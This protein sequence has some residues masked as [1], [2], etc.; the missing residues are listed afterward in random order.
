MACYS[1]TFHK[2]CVCFI[3]S[4]A[5]I[6]V[7]FLMR[8]WSKSLLHTSRELNFFPFRDHSEHS[9]NPGQRSVEGYPRVDIWL[10]LHRRGHQ[11]SWPIQG[12]FNQLLSLNGP[13]TKSTCLN[14]TSNFMEGGFHMQFLFFS[15]GD[16]GTFR[17]FFTKSF[18][19]CI[20]FLTIHISS[21]LFF[22]LKMNRFLL[23]EQRLA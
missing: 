5:Q 23:F 14:V 2:I 17:V 11:F 18:C 20:L 1:P 21:P 7:Y 16:I 10:C 6:L 12:T 9:K 15:F 13:S 8:N 4:S 19:C 22:F 3:L